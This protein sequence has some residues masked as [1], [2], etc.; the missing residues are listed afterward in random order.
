MWKKSKLSLVLIPSHL[1]PSPGLIGRTLRYTVNSEYL[2]EYYF[3]S[4]LPTIIS[5]K[6]FNVSQYIPFYSINTK[7][8]WILPSKQKFYKFDNPSE[9]MKILSIPQVSSPFHCDNTWQY[10]SNSSDSPESRSQGYARVLFSHW[11]LSPQYSC[12]I[13]FFFI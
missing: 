10:M 5:E 9:N 4:L 7:L 1:G 12:N 13:F 2:F 11:H 8:I 6:I 3:G